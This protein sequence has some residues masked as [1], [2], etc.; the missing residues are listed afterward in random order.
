MQRFVAHDGIANG[1]FNRTFTSATGSL[2]G[3]DKY[4]TNSDELLQLLCVRLENDWVS[5]APKMRKPW[6]LKDIE[7]NLQL[8]EPSF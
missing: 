6:T 7:P 1:I 4:L 3:W 8:F 5:Q 2:V